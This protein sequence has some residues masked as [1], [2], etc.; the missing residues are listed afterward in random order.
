MR[1]YGILFIFTLLLVACNPSQ[2]LYENGLKLEQNGLYKESA[3]FYLRSVKAKRDNID[4]NIALKRVA[5]RIIDENL[6]EAYGYL[7]QGEY[8][9]SV[10]SHVAAQKWVEKCA[11]VNVS[12]EIPDE[13][14]E[15]YEQARKEY[16]SVLTK[17]GNNLLDQE[18]FDEANKKFSE[19]VTLD[20][21]NA[22]AKELQTYARD[23][24]VYKKG[25]AA[26]DNEKYREAYYTFGS[27]L[28]YRD[29]KDLQFLAKEKGSYQVMLMSFE[30]N[31]NLPGVHDQIKTKIQETLSRSGD[32]FLKIVS[33]DRSMNI[34]SSDFI[35]RAEA[36]GVKAIVRAKVRGRISTSPYRSDNQ[37][38]WEAYDEKYIDPKTK[39]EKTR[40]KYRKVYYTE[41]KQHRSVELEVDA[42]MTS[43]EDN[44]VLWSESFRQMKRSSIHYITYEGNRDALRGGHWES[45][46]SNSRSDYVETSYGA[47]RKIRSLLHGNRQLASPEYLQG[48]AIQDINASISDKILGFNPEE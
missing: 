3:D 10:Y 47:I 25:Q 17:E 46:R 48:S 4:A 16:V 37:K 33:P 18:R 20:P 30:N 7:E 15:Y 35:T 8:K 32:P 31:S 34:Y 29:S 23:E 41:I 24:P 40:T 42:T 22:D 39:K 44:S 12:I 11:S 26:I 27:I 2:E 9:S 21:D 36:I 28:N 13:N 38:G 14:K 6:E 45:R 43:T 5:T 1:I 19:I